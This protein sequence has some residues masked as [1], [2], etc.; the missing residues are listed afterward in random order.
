MAALNQ[1]AN[2]VPAGQLL[3]LRQGLVPG[4]GHVVRQQHGQFRQVGRNQ[5]RV[6]E[7]VT[8]ARLGIRGQEPVTA[9]G[10][11]YGIQD[12]DG[13]SVAFQP[14]ANSADDLRVAQHAYLHRIDGD[15]IR[16]GIQLLPEESD[17]RDVDG[18]DAA[19]VLRGQRRN[20]GHG[21]TAVGRNALQIGLDAGAPRRIRTGNAEYPRNVLAIRRRLRVGTLG[22]LLVGHVRVLRADS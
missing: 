7:Q 2:A 21:V 5:V 1:D 16:D 12:D 14:S 9:A 20:N 4:P 15:V 6:P 19:G 10:H 22:L 3:A 18:S 11:H 17:R 13:G 8:K